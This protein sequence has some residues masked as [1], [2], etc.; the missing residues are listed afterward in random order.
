MY[1]DHLQ[2]E[3]LG[4]LEPRMPDDHHHDDGL[5]EAKLGSRH[6]QRTDGGC[7][8]VEIA[9]IRDQR[10]DGHLGD[11]HQRRTPVPPTAHARDNRTSAL[12]LAHRQ[13]IANILEI[14]STGG[15]AFRA[16]Q[17]EYRTGGI[18]SLVRR[19]INVK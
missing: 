18:D 9:G 6:H 7:V 14:G 11:D 17:R 5:E 10:L 1:R 2:A 8:V 15:D 3:R 4:S 16:I 12:S 13:A 19:Q